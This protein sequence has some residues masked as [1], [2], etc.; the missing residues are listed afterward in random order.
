MTVS[1]QSYYAAWLQIALAFALASSLPAGQFRRGLGRGD[2]VKVKIPT[3]PAVRIG[4][5][6]LEITVADDS[7][8][9]EGV[10]AT[11]LRAALDKVFRDSFSLV[12]S[13]GEAALRV[14]ITHYIPAESTTLTVEQK[15]RVPVTGEGGQAT[16]ED[17]TI[18]V[19]QWIAKGRLAVRAEIVDATGALIDT[20]APQ[21]AIQASQVISVDGVDRVDR[22]Q[23]PSTDAV[24]TK[25]LNDLVVQFGPRYCPPAVETEIPLAVDDELRQG[26]Q[27]AKNGDLPGAAKA[28]ESAKI[29]KRENAGDNGHN[30][31]AAY[32]I[33]GYDLLMKQG[34]LEKIRPYFQRAAKYYAEAAALDPEEKYVSRAVERVRKAVVLIDVLDQLEQVRQKALAVKKKPS[35]T[36]AAEGTPPPAETGNAPVET[37]IDPVAQEALEKALND[38]RADTEQETVFRQFVRLRVRSSTNPLDEAAKRQVESTGTMAYSLSA[39]AARRVVHQESQGWVTDQP[40]FAAYRE[41]HKAF[42][43][44]GQISPEER[45]ALQILAKNLGLSDGDVKVIESAK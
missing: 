10:P 17:K 43:Q 26:N 4:R 25:L 38:P 33:Q 39:L 41:S 16:T 9:A 23:L 24:L 34:P 15:V 14:T 2:S 7:G 44:D 30:V 35:V 21:S 13:N 11:A 5:S 36:P 32:E 37:A 19:E 45:T 1:I 40:K 28:W 27:L 29:A 6:T 20:F 22:T 31:G 3:P 18:Q 12:Q 42:A 8:G